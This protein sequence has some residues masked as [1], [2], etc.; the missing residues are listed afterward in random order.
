MASDALRISS[1]SSSSLVCNLSGSQRRPVLLPLSHRATFLGLPSRASSSS[2]ISS[3]LPHFLS[4]A[5]IGFGSSKLSHRRKQFSV[6]AVTEGL[7]F[8]ISFSHKSFHL[9]SYARVRNFFH[10]FQVFV[11]LPMRS[12]YELYSV[13]LDFNYVLE[14]P[15][16]ND[17]CFMIYDGFGL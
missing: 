7:S 17:N 10:A 2:S 11:K 14:S 1:S 6:F 9:F 15:L 3:S 12:V 16:V 13:L 8:L 4:K 5:R